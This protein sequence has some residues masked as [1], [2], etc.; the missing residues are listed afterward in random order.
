MA[1]RWWRSIHPV[2]VGS[3]AA[4]GEGGFAMSSDIRNTMLYCVVAFT[5][6]Y[7]TLA[8]HRMRLGQTQ[9]E[10]ETLKQ[11]LLYRD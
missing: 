5:V 8:Y 4:E 7:I 9:H 6:L 10:V 3:G 2:V 11:E 1:I